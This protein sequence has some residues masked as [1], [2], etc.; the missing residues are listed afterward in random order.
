MKKAALALG[1]LATVASSS[2]AQRGSR[3]TRTAP[4][5]GSVR[6]ATARA[7]PR[8]L[9][10]RADLKSGST[11]RP[12]ILLTGYWPPSND[13]V[14]QF[15]AN[16]A[17]NPG[18]WQG[19]D[20]EGRGYDVYAHFPE[21]SAAGC[22]TTCGFCG[23][24][25]G[26]LEVDYQDTSADFW[27]IADALQPIA[28]LT[29]SR[30]NI[31]TSWELEMNQ[32]NDAA[33][34]ADFQLPIQP[35]PAPPD[36]SVPEGHLRL[37]TLPVDDIA[38]AVNAAAVGINAF[39]CYSLDGGSYLSEFI[40]YHG[41]WYQDLHSAPTDPAW[42]IAA[43]HIHVGCLSSTASVEQAVEVSLRSL[44]DYVDAVAGQVCQPDLGFGGPG[45]ATLSVCGAEL[46]TGASASV[47][48]VGAPPGVAG[49]LPVG[50]TAN[51]T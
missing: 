51:P 19:A 27:P 29:F 47:E 31:D 14:R 20:W 50:F 2:H 1:L 25:S 44:I 40:A 43:G 6:A 12:A 34:I 10:T 42:C 15:S 41:V 4:H 24:G 11:E 17:Q 28:I 37:S 49:L 48:V 30:G 23:K 16:P 36:A 22:S 3:A 7:V 46:T 13:G 32:Y 18:G 21:F 33:W 45:G 38:D 8:G 9:V 39:I 35:T 5:A 26:E